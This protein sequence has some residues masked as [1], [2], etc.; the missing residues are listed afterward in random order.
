[1]KRVLAVAILAVGLLGCGDDSR[2]MSPSAAA[3]L[4]ADVQNV[5]AAATAGDVAS[6]TQALSDLRARAATLRAQGE[7]DDGAMERILSEAAVV[8]QNLALLPTT[9]AA[10]ATTAAASTAPARTAPPAATGGGPP[11]HGQGNGKPKGKDKRGEG[12]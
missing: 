12:D 7:L 4:Q 11:G 3:A 2:A 5:R 1:M 6:A 10:P 9:T 8:E